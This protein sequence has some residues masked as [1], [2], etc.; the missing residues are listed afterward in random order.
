MSL[1][2][3]SS[4]DFFCTSAGFIVIFSIVLIGISLIGV[5][6]GLVFARLVELTSADYNYEWEFNNMSALLNLGKLSLDVGTPCM[7]PDGPC[8]D[9]C[10]RRH[11]RGNGDHFYPECEGECSAIANG[12]DPKEGPY[13]CLGAAVTCEQW[14]RKPTMPSLGCAFAGY[15]FDDCN[16]NWTPPDCSI[17]ERPYRNEYINLHTLIY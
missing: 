11:G 10:E 6:K 9:M 16:P 1:H 13:H 4:G 2:H 14:Q 8:V 15:D 3:S 17:F 5:I 7:P 12:Q